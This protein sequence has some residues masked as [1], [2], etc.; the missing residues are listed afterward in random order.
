MVQ[1]HEEEFLE[2]QRHA[3]LGRLLAGVAHEFSVPVGSI[4]SNRDLSLRLIGRLEQAVADSATARVGE[5][6]ASWREMAQLDQIAGERIGH[7]VRSL[8]V[9]ARASD[10]Q[11][12]RANLNDIVDS[13]VQ[14]AKAQFRERITVDVTL[15][16]LP[17]V[18]CYPHLVSQAVLNLVMNAGQAIDG[19]G[20]ITVCTERD[21]DS[22]HIW[23]ADTGCG[24]RDEHRAK[25]LKQGFTT[26]PVGAGTGLGLMIVQQAVTEHGGSVTFESEWGCGTTFHIRIPLA[27]REKGVE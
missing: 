8:K 11:L 16:A 14:L 1:I 7:L 27:R 18:E 21:G 5:L 25:V 19:T 3:A 24:I 13:A 20:K 12:H 23:V 10:S 2:L 17:D 22:A 9:A 15:G 6:L 4:L 26:K